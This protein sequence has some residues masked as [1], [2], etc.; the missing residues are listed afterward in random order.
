VKYSYSDS[1]SPPGM[2]L[3]IR[4]S[5][6]GLT[7]ETVTTALIDTGAD[8]TVIPNDKI[9]ELGLQPRGY[10]NVRGLFESEY[11]VAPIY[12]ITLRINKDRHFQVKVV[13]LE[14][15]HALIGRDILN[16]LYL[17]ADGPEISFELMGKK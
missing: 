8:I 17:T 1:I 12:Y 5:G 13:A 7:S 10:Q 4:V 14:S 6:L 3:D 9:S 2:L 15:K 11:Q 16:R